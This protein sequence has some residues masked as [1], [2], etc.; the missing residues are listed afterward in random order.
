MNLFK[1]LHLGGLKRHIFL[2]RNKVLRKFYVDKNHGV[3]FCL[4]Y[5]GPPQAS[6]SQLLLT[7]YGN[8]SHTF[9]IRPS[10]RPIILTTIGV[11]HGMSQT[12]YSHTV[13]S[14]AIQMPL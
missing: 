1:Q 12:T 3:I 2:K 4:F 7:F 14:Y 10:H 8:H 9:Q 11:V 6:S 5:A 13:S